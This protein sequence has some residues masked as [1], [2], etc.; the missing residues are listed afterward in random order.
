[1][2]YVNSDGRLPQVVVQVIVGMAVTAAV[3]KVIGWTIS[4]VIVGYLTGIIK[5]RK[6]R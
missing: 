2:N 3:A 6:I 5:D 1:M 4:T